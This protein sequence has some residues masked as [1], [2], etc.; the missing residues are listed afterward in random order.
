MHRKFL[1]LIFSAAL[2]GAITACSTG[3]AGIRTKPPQ[4]TA[5]SSRQTV[6][7]DE[8]D[9]FVTGTWDGL[10][11]SNPWLGLSLT[12]PEDS[13]VYTEQ[14]MAVVLGEGENILINNGNYTDEQLQEALITNIYD[15]MAAF[16]DNQGNIQLVYENT[17][18]SAAG[19]DM[20]E[21]EYLDE[22]ARQLTSVADISFE[23]GEK[24]QVELAGQTFV[25]LSTRS[26]NG[27]MYQEFYCLRMG[28]RMATLTINYT[29]DFQ[30]QVKALIE[31]ITAAR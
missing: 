28:N 8:E 15:L 19:K 30:D 18:Y 27:A 3:S 11:F 9:G 13:Y 4:E 14:D 17:R 2:L 23:I 29:P 22:I 1:C 6:V 7:V 21:E 16:P 12:L 31:G 24:E 26:M 25:R 5:E 10:T 20:S